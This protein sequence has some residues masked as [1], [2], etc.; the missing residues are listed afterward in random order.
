MIAGR[1]H[2]GAGIDR[3]QKYVFGD[4]EAAGGIFAIDD[5]E[6]ELQVGNQARQFFPDRSAAGL[7][8]HV[9]EKQKAHTYPI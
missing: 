2:I 9:T 8:N 3:F 4:A 7:A 1:H 5:H 6:V